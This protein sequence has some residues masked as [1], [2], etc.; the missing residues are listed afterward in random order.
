MTAD[1]V[2]VEQGM[3]LVPLAQAMLD[4]GIHRVIV[5][6]GE[7]RPVGVVSST[8]ILAVVARSATLATESVRHAG[9]TL[10]TIA[11]NAT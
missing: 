9:S 6:D 11:A 1:P 2:M 10:E 8:D 5:V 3:S 4:G 7:R